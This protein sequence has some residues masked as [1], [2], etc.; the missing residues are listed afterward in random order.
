[1]KRINRQKRQRGFALLE[2]MIAALV[3]TVGGVAYMRLQQMGLQSGFNNAARTRGVTLINGFVEQ[4]R[5]NV[6]LIRDGSATDKTG[7]FLAGAVTAPTETVDCDSST[8]A[9]AKIMFNLHRY[10]ASQQ[11]SQI[12]PANNSRLCYTESGTN[13]GLMRITFQWR[14]NSVAGQ[15]VDFTDTVNWACPAFNANINQNNS[16]TMYVQL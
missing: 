5:S 7:S 10:L 3:L 11:M 1:M 8:L 4:L 2:V 13:A 15:A 14:D 16:V 9:C 6:T 12:T